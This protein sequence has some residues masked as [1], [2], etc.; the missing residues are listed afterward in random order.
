MS[1]THNNQTDQRGSGA[2][3]DSDAEIA[4]AEIIE[5]T[6]SP[7]NQVAAGGVPRLALALSLVALVVVLAALGY[8]YQYWNS[9]QQS[10]QQMDQSI[11]TAAKQTTDLESQLSQTHQALEQQKAEMEQQRKLLSEQD[12]KLV[13]ER[14]KLQQQGSQ[15]EETLEKV[16]HR[17]GRSNSA[18]MAAEAEYLMQVANHRLLLEGDV[19]TAMRALEAADRRL[20]DTGDPSWSGTRELLAIELAALKAVAQIDK[21]GLSAKLVGMGGQVRSLKMVGLRPSLADGERIESSEQDNTSPSVKT[22]LKDGWEGFKSVMVVRHHD[23]PVSAMLPPEQ[24]YFVY[25]NLELQLE[26]ARLSL[27]Q[28]SQP[29]YDSSLQIAERWL[30]EFFNSEAE[31]TSALLQQ[32]AEL[33][34][35]TLKPE[36]PD[37]NRSLLNLRQRLQQGDEESSQ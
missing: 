6:P 29:L 22:L 25:R 34:Q 27:L 37:I 10:L 30:K 26:S 35:V 9:L 16:F 1:K 21:V 5:S 31:S 24:Q 36:L 23:K 18:W 28:G 3:T 12:Q 14:E 32:L 17:V 20:R 19:R 11:A 4:D 8:G 7:R 2:V 33:Q 15:M 13:A